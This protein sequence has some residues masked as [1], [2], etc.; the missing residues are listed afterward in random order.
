M[1]WWL[2]DPF[3]FVCFYQWRLVHIM[4]IIRPLVKQGEVIIRDLSIS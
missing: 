1:F 3:A 4:Q 2:V